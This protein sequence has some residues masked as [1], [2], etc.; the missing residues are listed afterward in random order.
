MTLIKN[1]GRHK[2][3]VVVA[4]TALVPVV[5]AGAARVLFALA[6]DGIVLGVSLV[7]FTSPGGEHV[8]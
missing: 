3:R 1:L 8:L 6:T 7:F 2:T 4:V 5:V